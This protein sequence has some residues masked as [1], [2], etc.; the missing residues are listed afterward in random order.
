MS[1]GRIGDRRGMLNCHGFVSEAF[2]VMRMNLN[3]H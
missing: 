1:D 3:L 2:S